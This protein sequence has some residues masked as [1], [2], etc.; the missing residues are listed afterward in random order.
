MI[1]L[2]GEWHGNGY[3]PQTA[4]QQVCGS[5]TA[6]GE[7]NLHYY[8]SALGFFHFSDSQVYVFL[9]QIT[10]TVNEDELKF[11]KTADLHCTNYIW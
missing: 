6:Q 11:Q 3:H 10:E 8:F 2:E 9:F 1:S 4:N 7:K 5:N